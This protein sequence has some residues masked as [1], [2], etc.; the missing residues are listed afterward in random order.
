MRMKSEE[1][2]E[3]RRSQVKSRDG[4]DTFYDGEKKAGHNIFT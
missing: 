2:G 3:E 4:M 1:R